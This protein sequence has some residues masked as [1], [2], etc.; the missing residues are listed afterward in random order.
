MSGGHTELEQFNSPF[1]SEKALQATHCFTS[2]KS[3]V[4]RPRNP[5]MFCTQMVKV[6]HQIEICG[7]QWLIRSFIESFQCL[8]Y[9][10]YKVSLF[11]M[12]TVCPRVGTVHSITGPE[13]RQ[14]FWPILHRAIR[15]CEI[16]GALSLLLTVPWFPQ[17]G[18]QGDRAFFEVCKSSVYCSKHSLNTERTAKSI[19][20]TD[21]MVQK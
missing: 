17:I 18:V 15:P 11:T 9:S 20:R 2:V 10:K 14:Y 21:M 1:L 13:I 5:T 8:F 3:C 12:Q 4:H 19:E 16:L 7:L 6:S